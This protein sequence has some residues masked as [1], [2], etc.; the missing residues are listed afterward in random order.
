[1]VVWMVGL[2][3]GWFNWRLDVGLVD[4][5][6]DQM[7]GWEISRMVGF[8]SRSERGQVRGEKTRFSFRKGS[9]R[10]ETASHS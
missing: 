9:R 7:V 10:I 3:F 8:L 5:V 1:M 2:E 4:W 6:V